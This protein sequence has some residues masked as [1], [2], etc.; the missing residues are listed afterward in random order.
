M[1]TMVDKQQAPYCHGPPRG[2]QKEG[3]P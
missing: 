1:A 3:R 2:K